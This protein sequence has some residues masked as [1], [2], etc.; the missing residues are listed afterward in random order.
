M[1]GVEILT[2]YEM[3]HISILWFILMVVFCS[4]CI[5]CGIEWIGD[6]HCKRDKMIYEIITIVCLVIA[7]TL[8]CWIN[9]F[10]VDEHMRY[11]CL[12]DDSVSAN[13]LF[14]HYKFIEKKDKIWVL[15]EI[16]NE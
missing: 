12:M 8:C 10:R 7:I 9:H 11:E 6:K 1:N 16:N 2:S 4:A 3:S 5:I 14:E 13:E 15:E